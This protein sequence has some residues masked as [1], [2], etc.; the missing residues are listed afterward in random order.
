VHISTDYVFNG[1]KDSPYTEEDTPDPQSVYGR[2]KL[3]GEQ[4]ILKSGLERYF[5]IR[6]SWLYGQGGK[7]FVETIARLARE[8]E[9]LRI[10]ADQMGSPTLTDDLARAIFNLLALEAPYSSRLTPHEPYGLYH[11][12]DEGECSWYEFGEAIVAHLRMAGTPLKMER[13]LP[14]ATHEYPLPA[15]RPAYSVFS[16]EKYR[17]VAGATVPHWRES[18]EVYFRNRKN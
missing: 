7:N 15:T 2:S 6:T 18:L 10:V 3:L 13:I 11:F 9:E 14:I 17:R 4:E 1:Q 12:A 8:R 5:I 16:K